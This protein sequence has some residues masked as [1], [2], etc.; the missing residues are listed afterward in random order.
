MGMR[1]SVSRSGGAA[2]VAGIAGGLF[3]PAAR[4][5]AGTGA[6]R[7]MLRH[8]SRPELLAAGVV[9]V[10]VLGFVFP[11]AYQDPPLRAV[12]ET[13]TTL[14]VVAAAALV[15]EQ[16]LSTHQ[17]RKLVLLGALVL[18]AL[19]EFCANALPPA[20]NVHSTAD[21]TAGFP[22]GQLLVACAFI[23]AARTPS[24]RVLVGARRPVLV[25][26]LIAIGCFALAELTGLLLRPEL[27]A[28]PSSDNGLHRA[29]QNP[30]GLA[31]LLST[32]GCYFWAAAAFGRRT[33][34]ERSRVLSYLAE[35]AFL[36]GVARL[37]SLALP[38]VGAG[39]VS[40]R[41]ALRL[42]AAG[43]IF[44]A[45]LRNDHDLRRAAARA[46]TFAERRRVARDLHDGLAQDLAFIAAHGTKVIEQLG[47]EHPLSRAVRHALAVSR[48]TITDLSENKSTSPRETLEAIGSELGDRFGAQVVVDVAPALALTP[49]SRD[50]V[51][52]ITREAIANAARHGDASHILVSLQPLGVAS[53]LRIVDD[54]CGIGDDSE[55]A[56]EGF[57]IRSMRERAAA[58]GGTFSVRPAG[59]KGTNLEVIF[60]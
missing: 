42:L 10:L 40:M 47:E 54:G 14:F 58:L 49:D 28:G 20:L 32:A 2:A 56:R 33:W 9:L 12:V 6:W 21:F 22:F 43:F 30:L 29:L 48:S 17:M 26:V 51:A 18:L 16:F 23:A 45:A 50:Q 60:R 24:D 53:V 1:D 41:E 31:L 39:E 36:L 59:A 37:Y 5:Q 13:I 38:W 19:T 55:R 46:A 7:E 15:C 34:L 25:V 57:G 4:G 35:G 3:P 27:F 52:R 8:R 44:S 11:L